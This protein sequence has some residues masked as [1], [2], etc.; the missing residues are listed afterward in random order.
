MNTQMTEKRQDTMQTYS[1]TC[2]D[3]TEGRISARSDAE[4]KERAQ[5]MC[6]VHDGVQQSPRQQ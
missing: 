2:G 3:D 4:A 1:V 5:E 6:R